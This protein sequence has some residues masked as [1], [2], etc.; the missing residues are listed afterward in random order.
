V[1]LDFPCTAHAFFPERLSDHCCLAFSRDLHRI[2]AVP[3]PDKSRNRI[4]TDTRLWM[5]G[6]KS[7]QLLEIV[8]TVGIVRSRTQATELVRLQRYA[9]S[10]ST[11]TSRYY[12]YCR[13]VSTSPGNYGCTFTEFYGLLWG[14]GT[15]SAVGCLLVSEVAHFENACKRLGC[16]YHH[17]CHYHQWLCS[18][19]LG[20]GRF[21]SFLILC[22]VGRIPW[23]GY[24]TDC[25]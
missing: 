13:D 4:R 18:P 5:K 6:P 24:R 10:K 16:Y 21:S 11:V 8:Y 12:K 7:T 20:L 3:L 9:S 23:T 14:I 22:T 1:S 17:H 25:L 19:L 15:Y 2:D